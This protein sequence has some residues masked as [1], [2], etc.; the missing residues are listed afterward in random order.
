[1]I[2]RMQKDEN[3]SMIYGAAVVA[4]LVVVVALFQ[5]KAYFSKPKTEQELVE[6]L[7]SQSNRPIVT[8]SIRDFARV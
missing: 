8:E 6:H 4:I 7:P 3:N 1:M 5:F 2:G